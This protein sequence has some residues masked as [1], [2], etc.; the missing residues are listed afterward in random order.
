MQMAFNILTEGIEQ[1]YNTNTAEDYKKTTIL[2]STMLHF[3]DPE[4]EYQCFGIGNIGISAHFSVSAVSVSAIK[5][6]CRYADTEISAVM[7]VS[8]P[9]I[10]H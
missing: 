1:M 2:I 10:G 9:D 5:K 7:S 4:F 3:L 8:T 6:R